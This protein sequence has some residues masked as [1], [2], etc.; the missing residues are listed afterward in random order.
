MAFHTPGSHCNSVVDAL[1][2]ESLNAHSNFST[3]RSGKHDQVPREDSSSPACNQKHKLSQWYYPKP[4]TVCRSFKGKLHFFGR[5]I[6]FHSMVKSP[7]DLHT[8]QTTCTFTMLLYILFVIFGVQLC[9][10]QAAVSPCPD[11]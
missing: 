3:L 9:C 6:L 10:V 7:L 11:N 4:N 5:V 8:P 2:M 1:Q